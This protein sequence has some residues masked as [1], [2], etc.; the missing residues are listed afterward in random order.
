MHLADV[1]I[2]GSR[3]ARRGRC[4]RLKEL[5]K[6]EEKNKR[7]EKKKEKRKEKKKEKKKEGKKN[8]GKKIREEK[9]REENHPQQLLTLLQ[10]LHRR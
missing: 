8:E 2:H 3:A 6:K 9:R 5:G 7:K 4:G 1:P 10:K